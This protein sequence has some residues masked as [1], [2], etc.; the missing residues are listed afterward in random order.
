MNELKR[1]LLVED[2]ENDL[3]LTIEALTECHLANQV[4]VARDGIEALEYLQR[5]GAYANRGNENPVVVLLDLK[6]PR[7]DGLGT[8][9]RIR[10]DANLRFLRVIM[11][12]SS[13]EERDLLQSYELGV[14]AYVVKPMDFEQFVSAVRQIGIF[15][16]VLNETPPDPLSAES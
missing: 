6:M 12:T 3:E 9:Q 1:I 5:T 10:E 8:L 7:L 4:V 13:R 2:N 11:L 16:A 15:W 14:Q